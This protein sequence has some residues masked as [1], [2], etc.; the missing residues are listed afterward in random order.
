[1]RTSLSSLRISIN[2]KSGASIPLWS[3]LSPTA[4]WLLLAGL[5]LGAHGTIY[6]LVLGIALISGVVSAVHHAEIV[7]QRVGEPFGTL[8][9]ALAVTMI[10]VALIVSLMAS[11]GQETTALARD[12]VFAT[13]MIILNGLV[14]LCLLVG[15][16]HF[17]EQTFGLPG[18]SASL[19]TL[20]AI[21]ALTLV[22]P[23]YT[24]T[25]VGPFY[26]TGQLGF[27]AVVSLILYGTFIFI[28]TVRHRDYFLPAE[29][30]TDVDAHA[31][32]PSNPI[33]FI[34]AALLFACLAAV[35]L[36]AE[37]LAPTVEAAV[38]A[39]K[40][41]DALV[42][43]IIA[44]VVLMPEG[45]AAV[46]AARRNRLQTS[47]NLTLGSALAS[48]GFTIPAVAIISILSGWTLTLGLATKETVL[49]TLSLFVASLSLNTGRTTVLQG[50]VH[51]LLFA[52]YL[53]T[54]V[55]P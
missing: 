49:L 25:V 16:R 29:A 8:V 39:A 32:V 20:A 9:L 43:I 42:G 19:A 5:A 47:M 13:I 6:S 51:L 50:A 17:G 38:H 54:V 1:M 36:M 40:A 41:P 22:L 15:G 2:M 28:Q 27:V 18:V 23:N 3:V 46:R 21:A 34:S 12:T 35:V 48:I 30:L 45:Y 44:S 33:A 37:S 7:A 4:C 53:F 10:E 11:G 26:S 14:G 55:I 24:T 31:A 52:V